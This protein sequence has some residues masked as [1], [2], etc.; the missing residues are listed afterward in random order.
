MSLHAVDTASGISGRETK[1]LS[2]AGIKAVGRYYSKP[3]NHCKII[4]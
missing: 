4:A 1:E 3:K 2:A